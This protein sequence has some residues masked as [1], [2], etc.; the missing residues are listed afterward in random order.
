MVTMMRNIKLKTETKL[1]F[2]LPVYEPL[3]IFTNPSLA[4]AETNKPVEI[5]VKA[6]TTLL[7]A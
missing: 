4:K 3:L 6:T 2:A 7:G 5:N 1:N